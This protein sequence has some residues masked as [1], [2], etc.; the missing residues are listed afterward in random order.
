MQPWKPISLTNGWAWTELHSPVSRFQPH[1]SSKEAQ[2]WRGL[3]NADGLARGELAG[4]VGSGAALLT[5]AEL[6]GR[7][8]SHLCHCCSSCGVASHPQP[9]PCHTEHSSGLTQSFRAHWWGADAHTPPNGSITSQI[10]Y[11]WRREKLIACSGGNKNSSRVLKWWR[12]QSGG[13][14][15][16][17]RINSEKDGLM[18]AL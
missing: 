8:K 2:L 10:I 13:Q 16:T 14:G 9:R 18:W 17:K 5:P 12:V 11:C 4:K 7:V 1:Y 15:E 6:Q 3:Q